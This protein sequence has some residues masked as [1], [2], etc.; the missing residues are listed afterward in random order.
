MILG[1]AGASLDNHV[2]LLSGTAGMLAG[3]FGVLLF[4]LGA[5]AVFAVV[6]P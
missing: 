6:L 5:R 3:A 2:V 4:L 1:V